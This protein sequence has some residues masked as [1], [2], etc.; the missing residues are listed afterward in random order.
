M[1]FYLV[2][3]DFSPVPEEEIQGPVF[4]KRLAEFRCGTLCVTSNSHFFLII[5]PR[6][7]HIIIPRSTVQRSRLSGDCPIWTVFVCE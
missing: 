7:T 6:G 1:Q 4:A 2:D 5:L 3:G